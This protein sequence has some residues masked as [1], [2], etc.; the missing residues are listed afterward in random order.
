MNINQYLKQAEKQLSDLKAM[1][2]NEILTQIQNDFS[3]LNKT[4][5]EDISTDL[6]NVEENVNKKRIAKN[7]APFN[8]QEKKSPI[9]QFIKYFFV[10]GFSLSILTFSFLY[11]KYTPLFEINEENDRIII[12]GGLIDINGKE[13]RIKFFDQYHL[14]EYSE[15]N[16]QHKFDI[17][18]PAQN[19]KENI[20][21][22]FSAGSYTVKTSEKELLEFKCKLSKAPDDSLFKETKTASVINFSKLEGSSCII[23]VPVNSNLYFSGET[24]SIRLSNPEFNTEIKL[25]NGSV[26]MRPK[27]NEKYR[28]QVDI[29]NGTAENPDSSDTNASYSIKASISNGSFDIDTKQ[30]L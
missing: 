9:I 5:E 1:D 3:L 22:F 20:E 7:F 8:Y 2:K 16:Y 26:R 28:Y 21:I 29:S 10:I 14:A 6:G 18:I 13:G 17:D 30:Q 4:V 11:W 15:T 12:L 25:E 27:E 19:V 24:G 23:S